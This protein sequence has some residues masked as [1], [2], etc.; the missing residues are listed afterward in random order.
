MAMPDERCCS[1]EELMALAGPEIA[2]RGHDAVIER[3]A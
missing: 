3:N 2:E 1:D